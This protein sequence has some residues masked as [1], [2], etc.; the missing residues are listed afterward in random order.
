MSVGDCIHNAKLQRPGFCTDC[1][2]SVTP[3]VWANPEAKIRELEAKVVVLEKAIE[4]I[5]PIKGGSLIS[6]VR[7]SLDSL[8]K[9]KQ[10]QSEV[11]RLA[12]IAVTYE[13]QLRV[14]CICVGKIALINDGCV[15]IKD[16]SLHLSDCP[17]V[18]KAIQDV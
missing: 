11:D 1:M 13:R 6:A 14:F 10:L 2:P 7:Q 18:V 4:A 9:V 12:R 17:L 15:R 8:A 3:P 5:D 16:G